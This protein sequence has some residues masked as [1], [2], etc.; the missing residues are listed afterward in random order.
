MALFDAC[1]VFTRVTA[2]SLADLPEETFYLK[3]FS[4][5]VASA[6]ALTATD[7]SEYC[8]VGPY[9]PTEVLP[10]FTAH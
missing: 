4:R 3:G 7:R 9:S 8:R 10:L 6:S 5:F 2:C 1:S